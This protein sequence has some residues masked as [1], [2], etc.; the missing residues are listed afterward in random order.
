VWPLA[1]LPRRTRSGNEAKVVLD[2]ESPGLFPLIPAD[3]GREAVADTK[4]LLVGA[5]LVHPYF[6]S[7]GTACTHH[8][9]LR[10]E[11]RSLHA[12]P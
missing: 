1:L 6:F 8:E 10:M 5:A 9:R 12:S 7:F 2:L 4:S 3:R 11:I